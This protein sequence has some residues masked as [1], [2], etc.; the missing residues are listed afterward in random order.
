MAEATSI[1]TK[2]IS[3][4]VCHNILGLS[5]TMLSSFAFQRGLWQIGR[6]ELFDSSDLRAKLFDCI[7]EFRLKSMDLEWHN[8][9]I[10]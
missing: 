5:P 10:S 6:A 4:S 1:R 8:R 3:K 9:T 7:Q 2:C